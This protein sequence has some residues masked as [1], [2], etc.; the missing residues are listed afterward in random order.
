MTLARLRREYRSRALRER[1]AGDDPLELFGRWLRLAL[2][3]GLH[4]P[5]AMAL[6]TAGAPR[7]PAVRMVLLKGFGADGFTFYS[8][9][10]S[11]KARELG[12]NPRAALA[13]WW[14]GLERQVRIE[15]RVRTVPAADAD[16]YFAARP[17]G[18]QLGAWASRQSRPIAG[19]EVL[20]RQ[21]AAARARFAGREV[22]RPAWWGGYRLAPDCFEFWQGRRDRLHDRLR[23]RRRRG[24]WTRDRLSP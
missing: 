24:G 22:P 5:T 6:A 10:G 16:A 23:F 21:L 11:R 13:L 14:P 19:R 8:S 2:K 20:E 9:L 4:E 12:R 17:R 15:G 7:R 18:A 3:A 1:D